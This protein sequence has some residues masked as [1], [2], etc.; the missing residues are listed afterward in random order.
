MLLRLF[1][2]YLISVVIILFKTSNL[3]FLIMYM[4]HLLKKCISFIPFCKSFD[5]T[6]HKFFIIQKLNVFIFKRLEEIFIK[7]FFF[8]MTIKMHCFRHRN[9]YLA[10]I[11]MT[12]LDRI[13]LFRNSSAIFSLMLQYTSSYD[14]SYSLVIIL[15]NTFPPKLL[16]LYTI[17]ALIFHSIFISVKFIRQ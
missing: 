17:F 7:Y 6:E 3:F 10:F 15:I 9:I 4:L 1:L 5:R 16:F 2:L 12:F 11:K 13:Q 14:L 8:D